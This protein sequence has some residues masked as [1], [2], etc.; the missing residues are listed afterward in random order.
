MARPAR[1]D[2][3][4]HDAVV[5]LLGSVGCFLSARAIRD[6]LGTSARPVSLPTVY[7][8]LRDLATSGHLHRVF[9]PTGEAL[10]HLR[11]DDSQSCLRCRRCGFA[12]PIHTDLRQSWATIVSTA[13]GFADVTVSLQLTGV[14]ARC[15]TLRS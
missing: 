4:Q 11:A 14:C 15:S 7:R 1:K 10:Y 6:R 13:Y 5:D 9:G 8:A 12:V 2:S 3:P